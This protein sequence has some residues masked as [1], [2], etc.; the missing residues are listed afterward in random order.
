MR[1]EESRLAAEAAAGCRRS[2]ETLLG[3]FEVPILHFLRVRGLGSE[4][5]DVAQEVFLAAWRY[6]MRYDPARPYAAWIFTIARRLACNHRR[7]R[8]PVA[9]AD[10][11]LAAVAAGP[12]PQEAALR[13]SEGEA[14]W[15][16]AGRVLTEPQ[17]TALWLRYV[18][19]LSIASIAGVLGRSL[20]SVKL[21]LHRGR[22]RLSLA[23]GEEHAATASKAPRRPR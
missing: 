2:F 7:R 1:F 11:V 6:R 15:Q 16:V 23:L 9:E 17:L 21:L 18:E 13:Q 8:R 22:R 20:G 3:R 12:G 4:A 19:D 14:V 5:E 10:A